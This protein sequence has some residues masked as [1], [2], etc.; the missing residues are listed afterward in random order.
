VR[1]EAKLQRKEA[2]RQHKKAKRQCQ[3]ARSCRVCDESKPRP[4]FSSNQWFKSD[5][6]RTC[7]ACQDE[8]RAA[9]QRD[10][11]AVTIAAEAAARDAECAVCLEKTTGG[12]QVWLECCHWVCRSC[13]SNGFAG[14]YLKA[15][16]LCRHPIAVHDRRPG[17]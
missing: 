2:K 11:E 8:A 15:C 5:A 17:V 16:P 7:T 13:M 12:E 9:A 4:A 6:R 3:H 14:N 1:A 10:S